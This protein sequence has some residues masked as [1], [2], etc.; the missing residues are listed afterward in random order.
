MNDFRAIN[1]ILQPEQIN[2]GVLRAARV[3]G[4][5]TN[6]AQ[7]GPLTET[8]GNKVVQGVDYLEPTVV[9]TVDR[10]QGNCLS[11]E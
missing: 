3:P 7:N 11:K 4:S 6:A 5:T 8:T 2:V 1:L 9:P 10:L